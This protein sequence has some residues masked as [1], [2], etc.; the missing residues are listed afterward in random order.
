MYYSVSFR[1]IRTIGTVARHL[2]SCY[3]SSTPNARLEVIKLISPIIPPLH[4]NDISK[5]NVALPILA[6]VILDQECIRS[7]NEATAEL[8]EMT[9]SL[10]EF[11]LNDENDCNARSASASI[12]HSIILGCGVLTNGTDASRIALQESISPALHE[13]AT[14]NDCDAFRHA[15]LLATLVVS[16]CEH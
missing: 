2:T 7:E 1:Q 12:L 11:A 6:T 16:F 8:V 3:E 9:S 14:A 4:E 5:L 10:C 15:L 13:A